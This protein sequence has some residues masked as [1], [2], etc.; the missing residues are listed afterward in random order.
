MCASISLAL[1]CDKTPTKRR[2]S[3]KDLKRDLGCKSESS[4]Q[5]KISEI[6]FSAY[7]SKEV[8]E[9]WKSAVR[10]ACVP[11]TIMDSHKF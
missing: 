4:K 10:C 2:W 5:F 9:T 6:G 7:D 8:A 3:F 11:E 1:T